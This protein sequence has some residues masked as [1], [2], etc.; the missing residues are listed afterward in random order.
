MP[1]RLLTDHPLGTNG[2]GL[3]LLSRS[4]HGARTSLLISLMAVT[5]GTIVGG[6][7]G[8]VAG[9][10]RHGVDS[11][12]GILTNALL[13]VPPL[14]LLIALSTVLGPEPAQHGAGTVPAD[15]P[16]HGP[17]GACQHHRLRPAGVRHGGP[18]DGGEP[19]PGDAPRAGAERDPARLLD[20]GRDD[21][22]A[23]RGRGLA[24][25]PR[26]RASSSPTPRGAT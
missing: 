5:I 16:Q 25:L 11:V 10:L 9:Y 18:V 17:T 6:S 21:L 15:D 22:G 7:I 23:H 3:D 20:G 14:I 4:L 8:V 2:Q 19:L 1:P 12:V 13:A 26:L 24:E